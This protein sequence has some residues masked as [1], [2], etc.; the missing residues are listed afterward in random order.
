[1]NY[2]SYVHSDYISIVRI[3]ISTPSADVLFWNVVG[4]AFK[5]VISLSLRCSPG[6][7]VHMLL[8]Y[9]SDLFLGF[10]GNLYIGEEQSQYQDN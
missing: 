2:L 5:L 6:A 1:M 7:L 4:I 8:P 9:L 3:V 10:D